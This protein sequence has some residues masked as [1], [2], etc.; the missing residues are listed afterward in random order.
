M[1]LGLFFIRYESVAVGQTAAVPGTPGQMIEVSATIYEFRYD[2]ENQFGIFYEYNRKKGSMQNSAVFLPGTANLQDQ[3][4]GALD[5]SGSFAKLSYGSID[6]NIK[7]ALQE[8]WGTV[9]S[10]PATTVADGE[11]TTLLSGEKVPLT[12]LTVQGNQT[13]L[14]TTARDTG[15]KLNVTPR[16]FRGDSVLMNLEIESSEITS[17]NTFDRGDKLRYELPVV[18]TR[19]IK[20]VVIIPSGRKIYI[21]GLYTDNNGKINRKLP[22]LGDI[23]GIGYFFS[24]FN[25]KKNRT[26]TVFQIT[27]II[28]APGTNLSSADSS[29]FKDLLQSDENQDFIRQQKIPGV[30]APK[31]PESPFAHDGMLAP[32]QTQTATGT[33]RATTPSI[34][35]VTGTIVIPPSPLGFEAAKPTKK[36]GKPPSKPKNRFYFR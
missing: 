6:F 11:S 20:S 19:N 25:K 10:N 4:I 12:V 29:V 30:P 27:P 26:E 22:I 18:T 9:I 8:G 24:S 32:G 7:A 5:L 28:Q 14:E 23:P 13:K 17:F 21:G 36:P 2:K 3:P 15:I 34:A 16:I 35:P 31:M 33:I 1:L